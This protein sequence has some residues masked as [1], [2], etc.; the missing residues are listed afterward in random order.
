MD[1]LI[2]RLGERLGVSAD[3]ARALVAIVIQF[4]SRE[5][6]ASAMAPL[7]ALHPWARELAAQ[8]PEIAAPTVSERHFGGMARLMRVA[9]DMMALGL[10]MPQVQDAVRETVAYAR[11]TVGAEPVDALVRAVPGLRQVV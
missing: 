7:F 8:A 1:E 2:A 6:P 4:L 9:D 10:T 5:A 3:V 11:E